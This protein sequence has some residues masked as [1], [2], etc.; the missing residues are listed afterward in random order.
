MFFA[1]GLPDSLSL[2]AATGQITGILP[3]SLT[4]RMRPI[5]EYSIALTVSDGVES[6]STSAT[7][8]IVNIDFILLSPG[9]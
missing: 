4:D 8:T 6:A 9:D 1:S 7:W 3:H 5:R 2:D